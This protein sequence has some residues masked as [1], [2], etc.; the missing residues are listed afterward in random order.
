MPH[1]EAEASLQKEPEHKEIQENVSHPEPVV[2]ESKE[3]VQEN[4]VETE[5]KN[6]ENNETENKPDEQNNAEAGAEN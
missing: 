3:N 2:E 5:I 1:T 6:Q 4:K